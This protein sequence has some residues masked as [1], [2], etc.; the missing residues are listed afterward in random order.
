MTDAG[1]PVT[2]A[3]VQLGQEDGDDRQDGQGHRTK[4]NGVAEVTKAGYSP[5]TVA[6]A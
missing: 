3:K 2:G 1:D 6:V 4:A 5:A